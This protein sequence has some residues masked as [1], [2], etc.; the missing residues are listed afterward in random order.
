MTIQIKQVVDEIRE[1]IEERLPPRQTSPQSPNQD[2]GQQQQQQLMV[3]LNKQATKFEN[4]LNKTNAKLDR[5]TEL[6][7]LMLGGR[8]K[9]STL[10]NKSGAGRDDGTPSDT[11]RTLPSIFD[12]KPN[13]FHEK[14]PTTK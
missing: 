4:E 13:L 11:N 3:L 1:E 8:D 9:V 12:L 10:L 6:M 7:T 2:G 14:R 5:L